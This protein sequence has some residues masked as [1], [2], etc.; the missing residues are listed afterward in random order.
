MGVERVRPLADRSC[1]P[2]MRV[3]RRGGDQ[4][5]EKAA[6][7]ESGHS[8]GEVDRPAVGQRARQPLGVDAGPLRDYLEER[9][10]CALHQSPPATMLQIAARQEDVLRRVRG[11]GAGE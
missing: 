11:G 4:R 8:L 3:T 2:I 9:T 1:E 10:K 5:L 7:S 6:L